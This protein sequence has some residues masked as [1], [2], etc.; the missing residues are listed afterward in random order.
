MGR[1]KNLTMEIRGAVIALYNQH[2]NQR[3]IAEKLNIS[4][5]AVQQTIK[6]FRNSNNIMDKS[7]SGR[8][9]ITT[10]ALDQQII[11]LSKRNR[12]RTAPE[13]AS[14]IEKTTLKKISVTTVKRWLME[15]NLG[16]LIAIRKPFLRR[17][18]KAKRLA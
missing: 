5:T 2:K 6:K 7:K 10:Q 3:Y 9:R 18:S 16:G 8:P 13:I 11:L 14:E 17:N 4:K 15:A 1:N 12:K